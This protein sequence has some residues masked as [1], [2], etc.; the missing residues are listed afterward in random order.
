M[1]LMNLTLNEQS[2]TALNIFS[3]NFRI[4]GGADIH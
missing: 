2:S 4:T 3:N 1:K